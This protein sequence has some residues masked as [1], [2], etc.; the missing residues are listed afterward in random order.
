MSKPGF[1]WDE[2]KDLAN[3]RKHGIS[4]HEAQ[5]AFLDKKRFIAEDLNHSSRE[6]R[7][8]MFWVE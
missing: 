4:F 8:Y 6:S 7:Y 1:E 2:A 3:N 5:H